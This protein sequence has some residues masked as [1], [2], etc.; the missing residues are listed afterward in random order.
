MCQE[1]LTC[2]VP[3]IGSEF[4]LSEYLQSNQQ[5]LLFSYEEVRRKSDEKLQ[6]QQQHHTGNAGPGE[7][8]RWSG[9]VQALKILGPHSSQSH[10]HQHGQSSRHR[11]HHHP[12]TGSNIKAS[13]ADKKK[14]KRPEWRR[15]G[16]YN[17]PRPDSG[18]ESDGQRRATLG[19]ER[20]VTEDLLAL[21]SGT[22]A[23]AAASMLAAV[24]LSIDRNSNRSDQSKDK[25]A[26]EVLRR[27]QREGSH[28]QGERVHD[29]RLRILVVEDNLIN[30][31]VLT[32]VLDKYVR[33]CTYHVVNNGQQAVEE[34]TASMLNEGAVM[35]D[36]ILMDCMM[37]L[38][39][40][41]LVWFVVVSSVYSPLLSLF[42]CSR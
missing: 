35:Y 33:G 28:I 40:Q 26:D 4:D 2:S 32:K 31:K 41:P 15:S 14:N 39:H 21:P 10:S 29:R 11:H 37:V 30:Q 34:V 24:G 13:E 9:D 38:L 12:S 36:V 5:H 3:G 27:R 42:I 20:S 17:E 6:Q 19:E 18:D 8:K 23:A 1:R 25:P 22:A 16:D 7:G